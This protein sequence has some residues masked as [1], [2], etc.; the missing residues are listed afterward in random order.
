L[1]DVMKKLE[2]LKAENKRLKA[3]SKRV[4]TSST[5]SEDV[6]SLSEEG[7]YNKGKKGRNK[8]D[9]PSYNSISFNYNSMPN[10]TAFTS[11]PVGKAPH[12]DGSNYNQWK[13][14]M[15]N[16]LYSLH[17]KVWQVVC[18][19]VDFLEEDEQPTPDQLQRIHPNAQ[20]IS[21]LTSLLDKKEFN[22]VDGLNMAKD[23]WI[24]LR[25]AHEGS[26]PVRMA[27]IEMLEG[28][29][30]RFFI[31]DDETPQEMFNQLKKMVDKAKAL[32]SKR[33]IDCM[34]TKHLMRAY[35]PMNYNVVALIRQDPIYKKMTSDNVLGRIMNHE[36]HIEEANHIKNLGKGATTTKKQEIAFK[37]SK[38]SKNN[39]RPKE[40]ATIV[41]SMVIS[42]LIVLLRV[43][44]IMMTRRRVSSTRRKRA[45]KRMI[46]TT[47]RSPMAKLTLVK[48]GIQTMRAPTPMIMIFC[49]RLI[50]ILKCN[51]IFFEKALQNLL[52]NP[53]LPKPPLAMVLKGVII[54]LILMLFVLKS[55]VPMLSKFV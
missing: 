15:K 46:N 53:K 41:V 48:N 7:V 2:K 32:G 50:K 54:L 5:S 36:M 39:Q 28:Q 16:Y 29:L 19:G 43:G 11:I 52:A 47:R 3:K 37:A 55:N 44:M 25:M 12:F 26:K 21:V 23:I 51:L 8:D 38:K 40:Y 35:T 14:C 20:V 31:Y 33:W 6:D 27:K 24:T 49:K 42:L 34:L 17:P 4:T 30:D 22:R 18:D 9:K 10:S 45:T 13:Q 1:E